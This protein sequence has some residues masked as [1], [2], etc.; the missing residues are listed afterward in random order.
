VGVVFLTQP[1]RACTIIAAAINVACLPS[2]SLVPVFKRTKDHVSASC[3]M[4]FL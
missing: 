1:A 3:P 2:L 4:Y